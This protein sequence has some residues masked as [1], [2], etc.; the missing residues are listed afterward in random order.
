MFQV[1][2]GEHF[3]VSSEDY[4][5]SGKA[6]IK[7]RENISSTCLSTFQT[8]PDKLSESL[9]HTEENMK[10]DRIQSV[11]ENKYIQSLT[12]GINLSTLNPECISDEI[13]SKLHSWYP[14]LDLGKKTGI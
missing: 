5:S 13:I 7:E 4:D 1:E 14:G 6:L 8:N 12:E 11:V 2:D 3:K 9:A 10:G